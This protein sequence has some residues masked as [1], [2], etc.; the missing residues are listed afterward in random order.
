M[1]L[2]AVFA[3]LGVNDR[4]KKAHFLLHVLSKETYRIYSEPIFRKEKFKIQTVYIVYV[5]V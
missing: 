5:Y 2:K 1:L 3:E 4:T